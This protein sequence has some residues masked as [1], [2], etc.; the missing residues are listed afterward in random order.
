MH[1]Q[2]HGTKHYAA[3]ISYTCMFTYVAE[4]ISTVNLVRSITIRCF[5][6]YS[7]QK[8]EKGKIKLSIQYMYISTAFYALKSSNQYNIKQNRWNADSH[9]IIYRGREPGGAGGA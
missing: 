3:T 1:G 8:N 6:V 9:I 4:L 7:L 2:H 5:P